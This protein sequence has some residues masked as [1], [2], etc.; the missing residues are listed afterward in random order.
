MAETRQDV[1]RLNNVHTDRIEMRAWKGTGIRIGEEWI[2][3]KLHGDEIV[4]E[5]T[6]EPMTDDGSELARLMRQSRPDLFRPHHNVY[7]EHELTLKTGD[8]NRV[9][10]A[11]TYIYSHGCTGKQSPF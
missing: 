2:T 1:Y 9:K 10:R 6:T 5:E 3:V 8:L 7:K 4:F 11:W